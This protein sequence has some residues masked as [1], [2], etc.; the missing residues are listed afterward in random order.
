MEWKERRPC[1][2]STKRKRN[3]RMR[4]GRSDEPTVRTVEG[5]PVTEKALVSIPGKGIYDIKAFDQHEK[6]MDF[7]GTGGTPGY[8]D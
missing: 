3:R 6:D 1:K 5:V 7:Q 4:G 2:R 8:D